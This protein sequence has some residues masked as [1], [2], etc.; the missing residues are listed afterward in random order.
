MK[1]ILREIQT[2]QF[3]RE[4]I[5]ENQGGAAVMKAERRLC[6]EHQ[7]EQVGE[8]LRS[9]MPWIKQNQLVDQDKN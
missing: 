7:I 1:E 2:G 4:F 9:M 3:A 6:R 5:L 8:K